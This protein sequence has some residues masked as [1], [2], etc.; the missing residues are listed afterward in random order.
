MKVVTL[1]VCAVTGL[2]QDTATADWGQTMAAGKAA[3]DAGRYP[4]AQSYYA[5][6]LRKAEAEGTRDIRLARSLQRLGNLLTTTGS[7]EDGSK[8]LVR[9]L[10]I[11]DGLPDAT[12]AEKAAGWENLGAAY[13]CR[14]LYSQAEHALREALLLEESG[15]KPNASARVTIL[16]GLGAIYL[17]E[18]R[19]ARR[20]R[21]WSAPGHCPRT[22]TREARWRCSTLLAQCTGSWGITGKRKRSF[23]PRSAC[24]RGFRRETIPPR[25]GC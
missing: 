16:A 4:E 7:C 9:A 22:P 25:R 19:S 10:Q 12:P 24:S 2:A 13:N 8:L 1:L 17:Q 23:A 21:L 15:S 6:A 5:A 14:H 3:M 20:R 11:W 18:G